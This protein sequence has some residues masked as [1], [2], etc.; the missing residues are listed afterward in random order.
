M[1]LL[2]ERIIR[3]GYF[4]GEN[5]LKVDSFLNHQL[6]PKLMQ[7]IGEEFAQRF[8]DQGITKILTVE[9]SGIAV[10][11]LTGL[12]MDVPVVFAKKKKPSTIV[13]GTYSAKVYSFTKK[14]KVFIS[15]STS[16]LQA[17]D[18]VLVIDDFLAMGEA[19]KGLVSIVEQSGAALAGVGIVI[20]KA[21]QPGGRELRGKGIRVESLARI[22]SFQ[23]GQPIFE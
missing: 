23:D 6:D 7:A 1:D 20:E 8:S 11:I 2:K 4:L 15:V 12:A 21:F 14:E 17:S 10:A 22:A 5:I 19:S 18:T 13:E 9:A 3:D 16:F